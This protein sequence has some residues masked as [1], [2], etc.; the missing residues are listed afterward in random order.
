MN[1]CIFT[2]YLL[3][4]PSVGYESNPSVCV[5]KLV[6]YEYTRNRRGE[7]KRYPT[8]VT[9]QAFDSGADAIAKLGKKGMKMTVHASARNGVMKTDSADDII[10]RVNQFDFGCLDKD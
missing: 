3:F 6:T 2:G 1:H 7:K 5:F 4:D 8:T 9:F 10:F